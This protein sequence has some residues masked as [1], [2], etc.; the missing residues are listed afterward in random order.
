MKK[1][2]KFLIGLGLG[3]VLGVLFAPSKGTVS[4][5]KLKRSYVRLVSRA[6]KRL[7][8]LTEKV[9]GFYSSLEPDFKL[10]S[11]KIQPYVDSLVEG[12]KE[13]NKA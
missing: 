13:D 6:R 10:V 4:R 12:F 7:Q 1:S 5:R 11:E 9:D 2:P 3:T 8:G